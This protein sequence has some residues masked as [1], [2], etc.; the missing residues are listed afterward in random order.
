MDAGSFVAIAI[1]AGAEHA[2]AKEESGKGDGT[3]APRVARA[4]LPLG[5]SVVVESSCPAVAGGG[6][7]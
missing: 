2:S 6:S 3:H 4:G 5:R 7:G 1:V